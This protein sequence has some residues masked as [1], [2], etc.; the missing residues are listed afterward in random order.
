MVLWWTFFL[1]CSCEKWIRIIE[2]L[3]FSFYFI[4]GKILK[5]VKAKCFLS[6]SSRLA[7]LITLLLSSVVVR[8]SYRGQTWLCENWKAFAFVCKWCFVDF[9][10]LWHILSIAFSA[11]SAA[12]PVLF[13]VPMYLVSYYSCSLGVKQHALEQNVVPT[14]WSGCLNKSQVVCSVRSHSSSFIREGESF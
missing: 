5:G 7:I 2:G 11:T 13:D 14:E 6:L 3:Y 8:N 12:A 9:W 1:W 10:F 4:T